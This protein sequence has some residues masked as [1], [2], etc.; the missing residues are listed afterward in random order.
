GRV[1][2]AQQIPLGEHPVDV[3]RCLVGA[4]HQCHVVS[5]DQPDEPGEQWVVRTTQHQGIDPRPLER[6]EVPTRQ[7]EQRPARGD[8]SFN[9]VD[10]LRARHAVDGHVGGGGE[11]VLVRPAGDGGGGADDADVPVAGGGD[12]APYG[13]PDHLDDG[14]PVPLAGVVQAR[15][16]GAVAG[17]DEELDALVDEFVQARQRV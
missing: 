12:R 14:Y 7:A 16:G 6:F 1:V 4:G 10:E 3:L 5:H 13:R 17:D 9:E 2:G 15:G 8:A 11:G